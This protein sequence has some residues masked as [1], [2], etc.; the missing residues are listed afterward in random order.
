MTKHCMMFGYP[1]LLL[2]LGSLGMMRFWEIGNMTVWFFSTHQQTSA[3]SSVVMHS[4]MH[5]LCRKLFKKKQVSKLKL[6]SS[7]LMTSTFRAI[8]KASTEVMASLKILMDLWMAQLSWR[9]QA[10]QSFIFYQLKKKACPIANTSVKRQLPISSTTS[11]RTL[12]TTSKLFKRRLL[13]H[14]LLLVQPLRMKKL[15]TIS[16]K[17]KDSA[18]LKL[19]PDHSQMLDSSL[20]TSLRCSCQKIKKLLRKRSSSQKSQ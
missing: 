10:F 16:L 7:T 6:W 3:T 11:P 14:F 12:K 2:R 5:W 4:S 19:K 13:A 8:L 20:Q 17:R 1:T 18:I 9:C 15:F